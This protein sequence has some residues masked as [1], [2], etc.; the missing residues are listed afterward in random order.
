MTCESC[1]RTSP[2]SPRFCPW[3]RTGRRFRPFEADSGRERTVMTPHLPMSLVREERA[4]AVTR[5]LPAVR[6]PGASSPPAL[7][8]G[9]R[10]PS[11]QRLYEVK[12]RGRDG[13]AGPAWPYLAVGATVALGLFSA[14]VALG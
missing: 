8:P 4:S 6:P 11:T 3:C 9:P 1:G 12:P 7:R 13:R 2:E 10:Y 5:E 14:L